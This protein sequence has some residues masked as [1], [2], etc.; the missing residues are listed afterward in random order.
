MNT[1]DYCGML[2][3]MD[4]DGLRIGK[5]DKI[6]DFCCQGCMVHFLDDFYAESQLT[7]IA[8]KPLPPIRVVVE[9]NIGPDTIAIWT[10]CP[11]LIDITFFDH[12]KLKNASI[13]DFSG[14]DG[15]EQIALEQIGREDNT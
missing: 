8:N 11:D 10:N 4:G 3:W 13:K 15:L 6:K 12:F 9:A 5:G 1:C 14:D 7:E 2:V